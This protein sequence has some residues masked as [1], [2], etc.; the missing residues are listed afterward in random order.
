MASGS[1]ARADSAWAV[2]AIV[3]LAKPF[4]ERG[5]GTYD[6]QATLY[7]KRSD[8][9]VLAESS[10]RLSIGA[11]NRLKADLD[12]AISDRAKGKTLVLK[13]RDGDGGPFLSGAT[14]GD[15]PAAPLIVPKGKISCEYAK[16]IGPK[17]I[18]GGCKPP[19]VFAVLACNDDGR[20]FSTSAI[21]PQNVSG[22]SCYDGG[23][24][25]DGIDLQGALGVS[26]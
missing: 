13:F 24:H 10:G 11:C 4:C 25:V 3:E 17:P 18:A 20:A 5:D 15:S 6:Q 23:K 22:Q 16:D 8:G 1:G 12:Q 14:A 26:Q 19:L 7:L 2:P 9:Q 21:C